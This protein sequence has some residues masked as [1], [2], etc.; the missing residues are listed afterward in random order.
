MKLEG[1]RV[2]GDRREIAGE[3]IC[4]NFTYAYKVL[5]SEKYLEVNKI[6]T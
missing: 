2:S 3:R 1:K 6:K 5:K 4:S